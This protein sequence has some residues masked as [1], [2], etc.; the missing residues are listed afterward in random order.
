VASGVQ[1]LPMM[2]AKSVAMIMAYLFMFQ[3]VICSY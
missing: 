1:L 2:V 3:C